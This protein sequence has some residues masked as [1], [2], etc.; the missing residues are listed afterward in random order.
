MSNQ[1]EVVVNQ[2]SIPTVVEVTAP[3]PQG[4]PGS[5][6]P[7]GIGSAWRQGVGSPGSGLGSN[8]DYYL[9]T[10]TGDIYGPKTAGAWGASIY[11]IAEGQEGPAGP[12]GPAGATGPQGP[13]GATGAQGPAGAT[14]PAGPSGADATYS[15][16]TPQALG[17]ASAGTAT[18]AARSDHRHAMPTAAQVGADPSG[19]AV[20]AI[21]A[22]V[23]ESNPHPGYATD[24]EVAAVQARLDAFRDARTFYVSKGGSDTANGT[25]PGEPLL[26]I[27]AA[28]TA[29]NAYVTANAGQ[30]AKISVG[31]GR[32]VEGS[33]PFRLK[34]NILAQGSL[35][36]GTI[37]EP[38]AGQELNGFWALDS[39]CMVADFRFAGHQASGTSST[40]STVGTRAWAVRFNEQANGGQGVI[41][42]ASPYVKD[43]A[44]ITAEDDAGLAGSTSTGDTGGGV[45]VDGAKCH[46]DSPIRSILVYGFTQQN[47]GGPGCIIKNDGYAELVSFFGLFGTWHVQCETGGQATLS[48]GGCSEF[49][50]YG[51]VADGYSS[52]AL[53]TGTLRVAAS[54]GALTVDVTGMTANRLGTSSRPAS[55]QIMLLASTAYVVQSSTPIDASGGVVA[56]TAP[57][58]AG[59]RVSFYNPGG[60]GLAGN[61][62]QGA[63][64]D[65]RQRSQ[66]SAGCH[67]ANYVGSGTNYSALPWNGGVPV[68]ANEAVERNLGRVFG[69]I[70][71]DVGD[72]KIAGGAFSVD[73]TTGAVT[74]NTSQFNLSGLN[75]IGPFSRNGGVS[76]VG[77][78]LQEVSNN[79]SLLASTGSADSNT[80]PTQYAVTQYLQS[81]YTPLSDAR[82]SDSREWL[83]DTVSQAEAEAGTATTRRAWTAQRVF[84]AT[85]A[86]W[87]GSAAATKLAGIATGATANATDAQLRDRSTH[88]GTQSAATITGLA[89]VAT[90]G[91]YG[92]LSGRP[93][94]G[95][96]AALDSGTG[97]GNVPVLDGAGK[98]PSALLPSYVD[99]VIEGAN[100]AAFPAT[101]ETGKVY[102]AID[103][104]KAYR[105]SGSAYV[106]ISASPG[107]T[108]AVPE[109]SVNLYYTNARASAA[110]PVQSVAGRTGNVTLSTSDISGLG[111]AATANTGTSAGNVVVLDGAGKLPALDGSQLT[112]LPVSGLSSVGLVVPTGFSVSG[113][114]LTSNGSI[115]LSFASGYSLP[116]T[117][118]QGNWDTAYTDRLKWDGGATGLDATTARTS[119][120]L[121]TAATTDATAYATAAQGTKADTAVQPAALGGAASLNVGTTAGTVAAG[122]D[123][124]I[125]GALSAAT[126]A[127]TYQPLD[128][129]LTEIAALSTATVGRSLLTMSGLG[130]GLNF[131]GNV[132][133]MEPWLGFACSDETTNITTGTG[134]LRFR[135]PFACTLLAVV[136]EANTAPT[137]SAAVFDLNEGSV[138]VFSTNPRIDAGG[139]DSSAS[140]TPAVISDSSIAAGAVMTVDFDQIG[141]TVAGKGIK[142]WINV[143]RTA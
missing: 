42:T 71:N 90:S 15:D 114:P 69:L 34:P 19:S 95:T 94:L 39:G 68:R 89:T 22:H 133:Y 21:A 1:V 44:S 106:E 36:R 26:T 126:A 20:A 61:V 60:S 92:D 120:G 67:S 127:S 56:D 59:Y 130:A 131:T 51:L 98:V 55:G 122:N 100:L 103:T 124:R 54:A 143:R 109:G 18:S 88:T 14:G 66:I 31:P 62:S 112:G 25:S 65:F 75:A 79:S 4:P 102:V 125:T 53:Y 3:G 113:S 74:I 87:A 13:T 73:G 119:L 118:S 82:L 96:A 110:A 139:T 128:A 129:D 99:D 11:N 27:G 45:E 24:A 116:T 30:T 43:C 64:V 97:S 138:S 77:V 37:I 132:L 101:G 86:W 134:K 57:T 46:P 8:G 85:A 16:A 117:A 7:A 9:D 78:Q 104:G 23:A 137:G 76:T 58:R 32:F 6:G 10:A 2:A 93:T 115:T 12:T 33:L 72:V 136:F 107:S 5:A 40:D 38:A 35:Q 48:G 28:V 121:G 47:L 140:G 91:A 135:M 50:I 111:T 41:L 17:T 83:A 52:S 105:W 108:D 84:Q 80:A 81:L 63:T 141:S 123:S 142:M 70:V 29:A 49:G